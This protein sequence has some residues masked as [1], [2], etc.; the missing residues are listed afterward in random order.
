LLFIL[1]LY[2]D[3][4]VVK[5]D[6]WTDLVLRREGRE[7]WFLDWPCTETRGSLSFILTLYWDER[8]IKIDFWTD[9]VLDERV[10]VLYF[11]F[12]L[13]REGRED[14]FSN[15]PCT[16]A[17]GSFSFILTCTEMRWSWRLILGLTLYWDERVVVLHFD[18][19]PRWEGHKSWI[20]N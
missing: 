9:L 3:K 18:L 12:V 20:L 2:W 16:K 4:K 19:V 14:W 1:T 15:W 10:V 17:R 8:V 5:I 6:F 7:D 13:R 11:D